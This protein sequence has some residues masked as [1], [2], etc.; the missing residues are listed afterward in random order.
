VDCVFEPINVTTARWIQCEN[1]ATLQQFKNKVGNNLAEDHSG[2]LVY[3]AP[4]RVNL[5]MAME[6]WEEVSFNATRE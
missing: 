2:A 3:L 4:T 6:R 1:T 5:Q